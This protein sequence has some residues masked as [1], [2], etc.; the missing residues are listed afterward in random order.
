[1]GSRGDTEYDYLFKIVL[2]GNSG[3]GKTQLL[4]RFT[5]GDFSLEAKSTIG[6]EFASK[7]VDVECVWGQAVDGVC[8]DGDA[9]MW[10]TSVLSVCPSQHPVSPTPH[11][12]EASGSRRRFGTRR[13]RRGIGPSRP[14]ALGVGCAGCAVGGVL[15]RPCPSLTHPLYYPPPPSYYRGAVG[16]LLVYDISNHAS[17]VDCERWLRELREHADSRMVV[18]L[19]GNK[20]DLKHARAVPKEEAI[21]FCEKSGLAFLET[22]ALDGTGVDI[23]FH[24]ILTDIYRG[25][26]KRSLAGADGGG[27]RVGPGE[28]IVI[29]GTEGAAP[30]KK[31]VC[32]A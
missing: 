8:V 24:R 17:F 30:P 11:P 31:S 27:A 10:C 26:T 13:G 3:V 21:A 4:S 15:R 16:A 2:I 9:G 32:C 14:R 7:S 23:G 28:A 20:S 18:L 29:G 19:V 1:M 6:V 22:S 25:S 12:P 5:R